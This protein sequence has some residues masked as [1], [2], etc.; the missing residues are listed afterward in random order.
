LL[1]DFRTAYIF[2]FCIS[3]LL[4]RQ[5][6]T[7]LVSLFGERGCQILWFDPFVLVGNHESVFNIKLLFVWRG[8]TFDYPTKRVFFSSC[9]RG[10]LISGLISM[11]L[12]LLDLCGQFWLLHF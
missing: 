10:L 9:W 3:S 2:M 6:S 12:R 4:Y 7:A 1:E 5:T 8:T 11:N